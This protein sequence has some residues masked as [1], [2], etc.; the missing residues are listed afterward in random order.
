MIIATGTMVREAMDASIQLKNEGIEVAV[1]DMHTIKPIDEDAIA[2]W[3]HKV[4]LMITLE[5]HNRVGGLGG[6]VSEVVAGIKG[7]SAQVVRLG[8]PDKFGIIADHDRMLDDFGLN[9]QKV[10]NAVLQLLKNA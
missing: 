4:P 1:V 5:E 7:V 2:Y 10:S 6:A 8:M 9:A 3:A